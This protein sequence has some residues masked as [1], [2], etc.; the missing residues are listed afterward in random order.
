FVKG[1]L[2]AEFPGVEAESTGDNVRVRLDR[3]G[4]ISH[5]RGAVR[6]GPDLVGVHGIGAHAIVGDVVRPKRMAYPRLHPGA[7]MTPHIADADGLACHD[8]AIARDPSL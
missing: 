4:H 7:Q 2:L 6:P 1:V 3:E 5:T 8:C